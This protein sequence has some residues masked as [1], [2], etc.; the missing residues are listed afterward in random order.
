LELVT[1]LA[2]RTGSLALVVAAAAGC[3]GED[4]TVPS[5]LVDGTP[6]RPPPVTLEGV[7]D[8]TVASRVRVLRRS[9]LNPGSQIGRCVSAA[10]D[11]GNVVVERVGVSGASVTFSDSLHRELR[12]CDA[13]R[14]GGASGSSIWCGHA[15]ARLRAGRLRDPRLSLTCLDDHGDSVGFA[16][17][18]PGPGA[19]YVVVARSGYHEVHRVVAGL[20]V[21]V[22]TDDVDLS[23]ASASLVAGEHARDGRRLRSYELEARVSG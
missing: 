4:P 15:F 8:A 23:D 14:V 12:A 6:A 11:P 22:T 20:P 1:R 13:S 19:A 2:R 10:A 16:W 18:Q 17:I 3:S 7:D 9:S 21:R 5:V